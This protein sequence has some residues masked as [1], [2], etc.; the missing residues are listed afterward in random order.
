[1]IYNIIETIDTD[2]FFSSRFYKNCKNNRINKARICDV[3]PFKNIIFEL[4]LTRNKNKPADVNDYI[5]N[6]MYFKFILAGNYEEATKYAED[7]K[8]EKTRYYIINEYFRIMGV[9]TKVSVLVLT[10][11]WTINKN[12]TEIIKYA[13]YCGIK[14]IKD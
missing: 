11:A 14:I 5:E 2:E 8:I 1:M 4:E 6:D 13:E 12:A 9:D 7:K 3:C 10:G